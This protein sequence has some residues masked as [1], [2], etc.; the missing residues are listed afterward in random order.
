[1]VLCAPAGRVLAAVTVEVVEDKYP[2]A[3]VFNIKAKGE[4]PA[5]IRS[6]GC[7]AYAQGGR[8]VCYADRQRINGKP[9]ETFALEDNFICPGIIC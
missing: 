8:E 4:G 7:G 6:H 9:A 2:A 3:I 1:M 5:H